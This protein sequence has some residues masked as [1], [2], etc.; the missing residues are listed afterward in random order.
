MEALQN[1]MPASISFGEIVYPPGGVYGPRLQ[2]TL[3]LVF[4][5]RGCMTVWIDGRPLQAGPETATLLFWGHEERFEF[6]TDRETHHTWVHIHLA[7]LPPALEERLHSLAQV[8]PL[9]PAMGELMK[10]LLCLRYTSISTRDEIH[11]AIAL[12]MVWQ[13]IGEAEQLLGLCS[14]EEQHSAVQQAQAHI[15][16]HLHEPLSLG[17]IAQAVS[18]SQGHLI[19]LF[20]SHLGLTPMSYIW[21]QRVRL[22]VELL[23]ATGLTVTQI[24]ERSGFATSYHFARRIKQATGLTPLAVRRRAWKQ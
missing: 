13:Y 19:R 10:S 22:G 6:A 7:N 4:I 2:R 12:Q 14:Q 21:Q 8:I 15:A 23:A 20:H 5:H 9:S 16:I 17:Q 11:K 18:L 24:A 1:F 3:Q